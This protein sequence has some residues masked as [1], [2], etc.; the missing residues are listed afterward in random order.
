MK[1]KIIYPSRSHRAYSIA[2]E[3]FSALA[4]Q[5]SGIECA[6]EKKATAKQDVEYHSTNS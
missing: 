1:I 5:V 3:T 4:L 6:L 2:A